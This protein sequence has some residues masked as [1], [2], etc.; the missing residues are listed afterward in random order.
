MNVSFFYVPYLYIVISDRGFRLA[1]A[2]QAASEENEADRTG[3][4]LIAIGFCNAILLQTA[5]TKDRRGHARD[6]VH[7][8]GSV[9]KKFLI[10]R[11]GRISYQQSDVSLFAV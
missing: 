10:A 7:V 4:E 6:G 2:Q 9:D 8:R 1:S 11:Q 3:A 5:A